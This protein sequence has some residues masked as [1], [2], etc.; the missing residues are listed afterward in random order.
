MCPLRFASGLVLVFWLV[1]GA[2]ELAAD[3]LCA[4]AQ[5]SVEMSACLNE[6]SSRA[7]A[8]LNQ[9]YRALMSRLDKGRQARLKAAQ[10]AWIAFRDRS[11]EFASSA[12]AGGSLASLE[13]TLALI[14]LTERR[15][16]ELEE[17][18]QRLSVP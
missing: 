16:L 11:A 4:D 3:D 6:H 7:D 8:K 12:E 14:A 17:A 10:R 9:V 5:T 18:L 1:L 2:S 13:Y 15:T